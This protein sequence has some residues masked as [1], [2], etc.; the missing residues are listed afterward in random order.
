MIAIYFNAITGEIVRVMQGVNPALNLQA[1]EDYVLANLAGDPFKYKVVLPGK[2]LELLPDDG[3]QVTWDQVRVERNRLLTASDWTQL[4]DSGLNTG[5]VLQA[6]DY[7]QALRDLTETY[8]DPND[9]VYP[10]KP[11]FIE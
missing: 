4:P 2:T 5:Q 8:E 11:S 10:T 7:R 3:P 1:G 6:R 9:V